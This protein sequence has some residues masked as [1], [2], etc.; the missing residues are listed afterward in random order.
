[1]SDP[2]D[3]GPRYATRVTDTEPLAN[4]AL[5]LAFVLAPLGLVLGIVARRRIRDSGGEGAGVALAAVVV[6]A[7]VTVLYAL[8]LTAVVVLYV[9]VTDTAGDLPSYVPSSNPG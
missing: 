1:V 7:V 5:A 4:L 2:D 6:G 9:L 3:G 8:L